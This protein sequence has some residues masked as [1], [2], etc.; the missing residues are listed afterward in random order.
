ME[1]KVCITR[2]NVT[3]PYGFKNPYGGIPTNLTTNVIC[4]G[5]LLI[6]FIIIRK[7]LLQQIHQN[8]THIFYQSNKSDE[9]R[10]GQPQR[11]SDSCIRRTSTR[12]N[13]PEI[14]EDEVDQQATRSPSGFFVAVAESS[15]TRR[16][17]TSPVSYTHLTLPT[18]A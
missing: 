16:Q 8:W 9:A 14:T 2:S 5:V 1:D 12:R 7:C 18:K 3:D 10:Q 15:G 11:R 4:L 13:D 17:N 6:L